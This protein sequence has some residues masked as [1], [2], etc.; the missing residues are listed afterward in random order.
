MPGP[1]PKRADFIKEICEVT[2][3]RYEHPTQFSNDQ[4]RELLL[5]VRQARKIIADVSG[6]KS[7]ADGG[8]NAAAQ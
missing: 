8:A 1:K 6:N 7:P 3:T 4:L 2:K 5:W